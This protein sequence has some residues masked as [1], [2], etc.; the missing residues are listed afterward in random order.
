MKRLMIDTILMDI[1]GTI[2]DVDIPG[3]T[4]L[5]GREVLA[6]LL[7]SK[8]GMSQADALQWIDSVFDPEKVCLSEV[9]QQFSV[10]LEEIWRPLAENYRQH[11]RIT[12]DSVYFLKDAKRKNIP[13]YTAS[14]NS[15]FTVRLKLSVAGMA[16]L[17]SSPYI[18]GYYPGNAFQDSRGKKAPDFFVKIL[19]RG[20][21]DPEST[22]MVGD[23]PLYDLESALRAGIHH[24]VIVDRAQPESLKEKDGGIFVNSLSF[25]A[26]C[27]KKKQRKHAN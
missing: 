25:L 2:T 22:V 14:T 8:I 21:Y 12:D 4:T 15:A 7:N 20:H 16:D 13:V 3:G 27:I 11:T 23:D 1:D 24:C 5:T 9:I 10:S 19:D 17:N 26:D 6:A 18:T